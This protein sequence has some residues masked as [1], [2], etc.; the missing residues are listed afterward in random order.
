MTTYCPRALLEYS[1]ASVP[2]LPVGMTLAF[3]LHY[4]VLYILCTEYGYNISLRVDKPFLGDFGF[5]FSNFRPIQFIHCSVMRA[6]S[7]SNLLPY[8]KP[9]SGG[10]AARGGDSYVAISKIKD[11]YLRLFMHHI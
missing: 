11:T 1:G 5:V 8:S 6:F 10:L 2:V 4:A 7:T 9:S 3:I